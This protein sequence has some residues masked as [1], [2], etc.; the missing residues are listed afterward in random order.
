MYAI[1]G[2]FCRKCFAVI[3]GSCDINV[4][5]CAEVGID[6]IKR[7]LPVRISRFLECLFYIIRI[8]RGAT[9]DK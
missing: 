5:L 3:K 4:V 1:E 6:S 7:G 9:S 2:Q 8:N